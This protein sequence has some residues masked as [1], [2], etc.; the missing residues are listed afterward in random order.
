[1]FAY[2][3]PC[4]P[5]SLIH[6]QVKS[7]EVPSRRSSVASFSSSK[8]PAS[9]NFDS[10]ASTPNEARRSSRTTSPLAT[11]PTAA[12]PDIK[13]AEDIARPET[14][15]DTVPVIRRNSTSSLASSATD[16]SDELDPG[17]ESPS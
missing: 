14:P 8:R 16:E 12:W 1:M 13:P 11:E 2:Q 5:S 10:V 4:L 17:Q 6:R 15:S 7:V 3:L 9:R